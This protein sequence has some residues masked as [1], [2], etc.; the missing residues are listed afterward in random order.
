MNTD[1]SSAPDRASWGSP[2]AAAF[3]YVVTCQPTQRLRSGHVQTASA[4]SSIQVANGKRSS[5]L[6]LPSSS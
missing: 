1:F 5:R 6:V 2:R 4:S 3:G